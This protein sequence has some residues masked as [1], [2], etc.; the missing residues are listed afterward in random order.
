MGF[1]FVEKVAETKDDQQ[2]TKKRKIIPPFHI[3]ISFGSQYFYNKIDP[4]Q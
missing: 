1:A 3:A 4:I 2:V